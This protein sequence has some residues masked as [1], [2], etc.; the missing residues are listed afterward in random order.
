MK[1]DYKDIY[2]DIICSTTETQFL[3][4]LNDFCL[5]VYEK[6][7]KKLKEIQENKKNMDFHLVISI[8]NIN[9]EIN[10]IVEKINNSIIVENQQKIATNLLY[11][12]I[13]LNDNYLWFYFNEKYKIL[14]N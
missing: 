8:E 6:L 10:E 13:Q 12:L 4:K 5:F 3:N 14:Y 9:K 7:Y 11:G 2:F 1:S